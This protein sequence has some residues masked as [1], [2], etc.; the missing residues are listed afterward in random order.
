MSKDFFVANNATVE[1]EIQHESDQS[2][3]D[4]VLEQI[5]HQALLDGDSKKAK[6]EQTA[7]DKRNKLSESRRKTGLKL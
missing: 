7:K 4:K 1:I 3:N 6:E 5:N 2:P